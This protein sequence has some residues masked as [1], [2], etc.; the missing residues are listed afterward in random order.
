MQEKPIANPRF[1]SGICPHCGIYTQWDWKYIKEYGQYSSYDRLGNHQYEY[2]FYAS[3]C[4]N[5]YKHISYYKNELIYPKIDLLI[6]PNIILDDYP[7]SKKLFMESVKVSPISPRAGLT[8]SRMCLEA[9][10][11][12][13]LEK[14]NE[15][16]NKDFNK[17]ID[18]LFELD[19]I[20]IK[21]KK[22]LSSTRIIGNK[23]THNFNIIDTENEPTVD[24]CI[25]V[26][27]VIDYILE[28]IR[29]AQEKEE[30]LNMLEKKVKGENVDN[31]KI[32]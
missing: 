20:T 15:K 2:Y 32:E 3:E 11:N 16:P 18:K 30:K 27:E 14:H 26:L 7:K 23:T 21:I 10:T 31:I 17:N 9:L 28:N 5:C 12:E 13:I 22:L 6:K 29:I 19:I 24:D 1:S 25:T 4:R 8:L